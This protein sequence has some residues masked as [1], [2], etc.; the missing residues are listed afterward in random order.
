MKREHNW[1]RNN[2]RVHNLWT[3]GGMLVRPV[4]AKRSA[5]TPHRLLLS[6]GSPGDGKGLLSGN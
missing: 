4:K 5:C 1:Y 3:Y 2:V 6:R